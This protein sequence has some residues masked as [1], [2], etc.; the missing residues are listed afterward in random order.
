MQKRLA[1]LIRKLDEKLLGKYRF[2]TK[3]F[4]VLAEIQKKTGI[5]HDTRPICPFLRPHFFARSRYEKIKY[6]AET[7]N[8]VFERMT[9]ATLENAEIMAEINL[10]EK[11]ERLAR[12]IRSASI[13]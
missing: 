10:T 11:E 1:N 5:L 8:L 7:L 13:R 4:S 3:M 9:E 2:D 12:L 6:A